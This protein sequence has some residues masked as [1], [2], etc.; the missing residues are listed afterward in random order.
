[1]I[2]VKLRLALDIENEVDA[3]TKR[4]QEIGAVV[5]EKSQEKTNLLLGLVSFVASL[6][7][8]EPFWGYAVKVQEYFDLPEYAAHI[9]LFGSGGSILA[10]VFFM[11][12]KIK[13]YI[14]RCI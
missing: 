12:E 1:M 4:I 11:P 7:A 6:S 5:K 14:N 2:N 9:I 10:F 13:A 8:I 3:L